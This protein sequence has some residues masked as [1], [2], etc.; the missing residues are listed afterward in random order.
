MKS[1]LIA[2][3]SI[4]GPTLAWWLKR[5][6]FAPTLV[7]KAP[8][9]RPGGHAIDIR[10]AALDVVR[11]MGIA[12]EITAR[13]TRMTGV[14]KLNAA[15]EE[16]WRSEEMTISGGSFGAAAVEILRDDLS[17]VLISALPP[18]VELIYGDSV[19]SV[20]ERPDA[21]T[22]GFN[23][24][25]ERSFDL[26]VGADGMASSMRKMIFGGDEQFVHP[27]DIVLAPYTAPNSLGLEDWQLTYNAG[28]DS[29]MIYTA[30]GNAAL[31]VCFGFSAKL[32]DVPANRSAQIALVRKNCGHMGWEVPRLLD[33]M[34]QAK[35][36]YLGPIAQVKMERWTKGH[37]ALVGDA[38][39]CPSPFTGQGTSLAIV[40]A[41]VL[42]WELSHSPSD[43]T[44][45]FSRYEERMRP[46]VE[47]NQAIAD[48][49]RDPR[50]G[51]DP[52]YYLTVIEPAMTKAERA[53]NLPSFDL[54][55]SPVRATFS[56]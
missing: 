13:R 15:G 44:A 2:G 6:G 33:A 22:V 55:Q 39:Y 5:F 10:G 41:Y 9:P 18:G 30:P 1:V 3:A 50:F 21:I 8:A 14:S 20:T 23:K 42:A 34:E 17:D 45:A 52:D 56:P 36:F 40:G 27:F 46:F 43:H 12:D 38:A 28:K 37:V 49:S 31:R 35:D 51:E 29:C 24:G 19:K 16:V 26:V 48:L 11:A 25:P 7:E 32:A 47:K 4:A 53:I 54:A